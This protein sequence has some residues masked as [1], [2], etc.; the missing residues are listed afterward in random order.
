MKAV[1]ASPEPPRRASPSAQAGA[2]VFGTTLATLSSALLPLLLV[3]LLGKGDIAELMALVL[4]YETVALVTTLGFPQTLMYHLPSLDKLERKAVAKR[5]GFIMVG[6]GALS[7]AITTAIGIWG[8]NLPGVLAS[9]AGSRIS[10]RPLIVL[11]PSLLMELPSRVVPNLLVAEHRARE[12]SALGVVR[13]I[14]TTAATLIPVALGQNIWVVAAWYSAC[15]FLLG[16]SLPWAIRL[17]YGDEPAPPA[18][19]GAKQLFRFALPLGATDIVSLL[20]QQFDRW[21]ILLSFP[22]AAFADYQAGAWQVPVISTIAYSVGAAYMPSM[23]EDFKRGAPRDAINTWRGTILK[24][25]LI[26]VPVTMGFVVGARELMGIMFTK[27]YVGAAPVFQLYSALTLGRVA[28]F[29]SVIVAAGRPR[30][31]L[32]AALLS[33]VANVVLAI[34]LTRMIG[35]IGPALA[36]VLAFIPT[37]AFYVWAIGRAAGLPT[38]EVFPL[39]GYLRILGLAGLAGLVAWLVKRQLPESAPLALLTAVVV[40]LGAFALLATLTGTV[41]RSDWRYLRDWMKLKFAR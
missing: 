29:G 41:A 28:A 36:T 16:L 9:E 5:V 27:A 13:T 40:T 10:L 31:V 39:L 23:V 4:V 33:F 17:A 25:S 30:Y 34:P 14:I 2:L 35:F 38:R 15:R 18:S 21:L 1:E 8:E 6:L 22:A 24:V 7:A 11:A 3:R 32:Q 26:V 12:A 19:V 37:V 20:N